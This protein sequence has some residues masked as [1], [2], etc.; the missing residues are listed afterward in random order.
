MPCSLSAR[1]MYAGVP[2]FRSAM[3]GVGTAADPERGV[4]VCVCCSCYFSPLEDDQTNSPLVDLEAVFLRRSM[5]SFYESQIWRPST[6]LRSRWSSKRVVNSFSTGVPEPKSFGHLS[7]ETSSRARYKGSYSPN[8]WICFSTLP[9]AN[10]PDKTCQT[11]TVFFPFTS[12]M[13][14]PPL[15][16]GVKFQ[17]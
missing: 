1:S 13:Y 6:I 4:C 8:I 15:N 17:R 14:T 9:P 11:P 2:Q 5:F 3:F 16:P 7:M 12:F 10:S